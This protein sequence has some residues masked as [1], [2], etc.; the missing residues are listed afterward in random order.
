MMLTPQKVLQHLGRFVEDMRIKE[1]FRKKKKV[2]QQAEA[3]FAMV[4]DIKKGFVHQNNQL[5]K[6]ALN[7]QFLDAEE[8]LLNL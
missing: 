1:M 7:S 2:E 4:S 5:N 3:L 6:S 8:A